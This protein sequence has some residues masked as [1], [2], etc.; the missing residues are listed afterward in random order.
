MNCINVL[1]WVIAVVA[2]IGWVVQTVRYNTLTM[3]KNLVE[4]QLASLKKTIPDDD[5][6]K[7]W[8]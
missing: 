5:A 7:S 2:S 4:F 8:G 3:E 6:G 1:G